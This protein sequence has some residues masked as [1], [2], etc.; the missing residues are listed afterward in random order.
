MAEVSSVWPSP[1]GGLACAIYRKVARGESIT[2]STAVLDRREARN[3]PVCVLWLRLSEVMPLSID[4]APTFGRIHISTSR[5]F[6]TAVVGSV[7]MSNHV[8][9]A[10]EIAK[11]FILSVSFEHGPGVGKSNVLEYK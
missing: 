1:W 9:L 7:H 4:Q 2:F 3:I 6:D 10:Q 5:V 11:Q 8:S